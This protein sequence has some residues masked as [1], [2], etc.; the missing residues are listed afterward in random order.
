M[1]IGM[2]KL[3]QRH[4]IGDIIAKV[5][6]IFPRLDMMC[7]HFFCGTAFLTGSMISLQD[8]LA[9]GSIFPASTFYLWIWFLL[10]IIAAFQATEFGFQFAAGWIEKLTAPLAVQRSSWSMSLRSQLARTR[11]RTRFLFE[12]VGH[13]KFLPADHANTPMAIWAVVAS[14][15]VNCKWLLT[16]SAI[17]DQRKCLLHRLFAFLRFHEFGGLA[18]KRTPK[19]FVKVRRQESSQCQ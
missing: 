16:P 17:S 18:W 12:I 13:R 6:I 7:T 3:T 4:T 15:I 11:G 19:F 5:G 2:T 10:G 8:S 1:S 9:P 14:R